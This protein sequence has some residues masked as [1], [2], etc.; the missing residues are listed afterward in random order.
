MQETAEAGGTLRGRWRLYIP[1]KRWTLPKLQ[2]VTAHKTVLLMAIAE[3][4]PEPTNVLLSLW[5][6]ISRF[7]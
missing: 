1:S 7:A 6:T 3:R 4:T 2:G 5:K